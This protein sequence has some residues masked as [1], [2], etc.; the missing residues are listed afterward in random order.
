RIT[1]ATGYSRLLPAG[2]ADHLYLAVG[3]GGRE[4]RRGHGAPVRLIAPGRRGPWWVKWVTEVE[5]DDRPWWLQLP[6]PP[7]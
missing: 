4:L 6:F 1:S 7:T 5:L 2:D 3:Y